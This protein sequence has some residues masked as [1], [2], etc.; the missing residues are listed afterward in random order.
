[1][2]KRYQIFTIVL[3]VL[4]NCLLLFFY[5]QKNNEAPCVARDSDLQKEFRE[6]NR[7]RNTRFRDS[8][9]VKKNDGDSI[10]LSELSKDQFYLYI[11]PNQCPSCLLDALT[12]FASNKEF[13]VTYLIGSSNIAW[14]KYTAE[15]YNLVN[16][17]YTDSCVV[18]N[19]P[20]SKPVA[21][22]FGDDNQISSL[23]VMTGNERFNKFYLNMMLGD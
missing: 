20:F 3:L 15:K 11:D 8:I 4:I 18:E 13:K 19:V 1:M 23:F 7:I 21:V 10:L 14:L 6:V 5:K 9:F 12:F 2:S 22:T 17:Y 16:Y